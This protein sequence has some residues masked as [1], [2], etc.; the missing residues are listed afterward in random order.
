ME[1]L[2][3]C[4]LAGQR[5]L[6]FT[7]HRPVVR[8]RKKQKSRGSGGLLVVE[9]V[10]FAAAAGVCVQQDGFC[11]YLRLPVS[12]DPLHAEF[13]HPL[14]PSK[15]TYRLRRLRAKNTAALELLS[16]LRRESGLMNV[17]VSARWAGVKR[18]ISSKLAG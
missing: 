15:S 14:S 1:C 4:W 9:P 5:D 13:D 7:I 6:F 11:F 10:G 8:D 18:R 2:E 3:G 17:T 16:E 12:V